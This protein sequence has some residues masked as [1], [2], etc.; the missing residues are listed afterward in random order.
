MTIS[1]D[2][3]WVKTTNLV[4]EIIGQTGGT[5]LAETDRHEI[6]V[7]RYDMCINWDR[8]EGDFARIGH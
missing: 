3:L 6:Y 5:Q 4:F 8:T 1:V 7:M 2:I